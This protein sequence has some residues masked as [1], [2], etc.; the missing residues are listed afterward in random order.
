MGSAR[1]FAAGTS[2]SCSRTMAPY[3]PSVTMYTSRGSISGARR[4]TVAW[5][6]VVS[7]TSGRKGLGLSARLSGQRRVPPPPAMITAYMRVS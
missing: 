1:M 6:S 3:R 7:P 2:G 5:S 4:A